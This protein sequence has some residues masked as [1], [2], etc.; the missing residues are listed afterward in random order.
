MQLLCALVLAIC[1]PLHGSLLFL[2]HLYA[3]G[4]AA[5]SRLLCPAVSKHKVDAFLADVCL[6]L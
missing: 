5:W 1:A 4:C 2:L 6:A 3:E